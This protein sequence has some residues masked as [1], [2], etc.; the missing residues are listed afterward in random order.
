[1]TDRDHTPSYADQAWQGT[2]TIEI[3][4]SNVRIIGEI[5]LDRLIQKAPITAQLD[6]FC[7]QLDQA[8]IRNL[9][10]SIHC[11]KAIGHLMNILRTARLPKRGIHLHA[12]NGPVE[13]I[14][15][16]VRLGARFSFNAGQLKPQS[17]KIVKRVQT[18]PLNRLLIETD[19]PNSLPPSELRTFGLPHDIEGNTH[20]HPATLHDGYT[21]IGQLLNLTIYELADYIAGNFKVYF[22]N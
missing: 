19:A 7:W 1:M 17:K 5:G 2:V 16:L 13:L 22:L 15:E 18:V 10:V 11:N 9:P 14:A 20:T 6:A 12:Y 4:Q 21:A 8:H 3:R